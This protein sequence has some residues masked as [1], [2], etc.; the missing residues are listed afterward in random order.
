MKLLSIICVHICVLWAAS[1]PSFSQPAK[2]KPKAQ[3]DKPKAVSA[4]P[5]PSAT[6]RKSNEQAAWERAVNTEGRDA[7]ITA[8]V[9]FNT[10]F[11]KSAKR[12]DAVLTIVLLRIDAGNEKLAAGELEAAAAA[13]KSAAADAPKPLP[14]QL[15]SEALSKIAANLY[16]RGGRT[17]AVEIEKIFEEKTDGNSAQLLDIANFYL[18]IENGADAKRVAQKAIALKPN[19]SVAYQTLGLANRIDFELE[20]SATAYAKA[21]EIEPTSAEAKRGLAEMKRALGKADE[22]VTLYREVLASN[23]TDIPSETGLI[24]ALFESGKRTEAEGE[25]AKSLET[26]PGNVMLLAGAAYWYAAIGDGAKAVELAQKAIESNPRFIWS[27][28]ALA[29]ALLLQDKAA[30]AEKTLLAARQYGNFPTLEYELASARL[31]AGYY[32]EAADALAARFSIADGKVSTKLGGRVA[33]D[34]Q[35]FTELVG[36]E[37]R[38]SIFAPNAADSSENAGRLAALLKF[39]QLLS[40]K[41]IDAVTVAIAA[42]EFA[43]G[44]DKNDKMKV[45]RQVFAASQLL[46]KKAALQKV[47]E[48]TRAATTGVDNGLNSAHATTAV[49]ASELYENRAIAAIKGEYIV[50]PDVPRATLSA[51]LRG[52]IE[53]ISGW[54]QYNLGAAD[55]AVVRLRRAVNV[56]PVDSAWWRSS[57]W[58]LAA[59]LALAG[60]DAEALDTYIKSYRSYGRPDIFRYSVIEALYR[61][62]NGN[63]D[64]LADKIG[65]KPAPQISTETLAQK[66]EPTATPTP[67]ISPTPTP[68]VKTETTTEIKTEP[69][70]TPTPISEVSPTPTAEP[71]PTPTPTETKP[72]DFFP[73]V[74]ITIPSSEKKT[75][76]SPSTE[77]KTEV[78][79]CKL[80]VSEETINLPTG[81]KN[82]AVIVGLEDDAEFETVEAVSSSPQDVSVR[83]EPITGVKTRAIF[84]LRTVSDRVG[85]YQVTF[86]MPCGK[87][88]ITVNVR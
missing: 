40:V 1:I 38:A 77:P 78:K 75:E 21:L 32:R 45:H 66:V 68:E 22:A 84:V 47:L 63:T 52:R 65:P 23:A 39:K 6:P 12:G 7:R 46:E 80:T 30:D 5:K 10:D 28:I 2:S 76:S 86:V 48:L 82:L 54:A 62:V 42:E 25:L 26:N 29:R 67:E 27:H 11:P 61:K 57:T 73:P 72:K 50:F 70:A 64:G 37:R 24:L 19:S 43:A 17:D 87:R 59:A 85:V 55:D 88:S 51:I 79:S 58:R 13:F 35:N 9:K 81:G 4:K 8:L 33:R 53:E 18:T 3:P 83:R 34:A 41:E 56:L 31:A 74:V 15:W 44:S 71:T 60:K 20:D 14:D 16:F 49:M 36:F 69:T